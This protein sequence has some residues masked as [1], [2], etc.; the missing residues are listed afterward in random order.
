[1]FVTLFP[2][3]LS[4]L[5]FPDFHC[6]LGSH[7]INVFLTGD[8]HYCYISSRG[9][10][11]IPTM[12]IPEPTKSHFGPPTILIFVDVRIPLQ[13]AT[14]CSPHRLLRQQE[15]TPPCSLRG[16]RLKI[17]FL[18]V[19]YSIKVFPHLQ[20]VSVLTEKEVLLYMLSCKLSL[21]S[22][23]VVTISATADLIGEQS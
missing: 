15:V 7:E 11:D 21:Q 19:A 2:D 9:C 14:F 3:A 13:H 18:C 12:N 10:K 8:E 23:I 5:A 22:P 4:K 1:M 16:H 6:C 17:L 20:V